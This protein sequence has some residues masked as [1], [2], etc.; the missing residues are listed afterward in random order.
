MVNNIDRQFEETFIPKNWIA[1]ITS[2]VEDTFYAGTWSGAWD[3]D[4]FSKQFK[5]ICSN[6]IKHPKFVNIR[7]F[8]VWS[9]RWPRWRQIK[10]IENRSKLRNTLS[11]DSQWTK[12]G[13]HDILSV[14]WR[15]AHDVV[16]MTADDI[17]RYGWVVQLFTNVLEIP[18]LKNQ[19]K[20]IIK[21]YEQFIIELEK[22]AG[23]QGFSVFNW[24]TAQTWACVWTPITCTIDNPFIA[25]PFNRAWVMQGLYHEERMILGDKIQAWD[26]LVALKQDWFRSNGI[27][28]VRKWF[29]LQYGKNRYKDAPREE[30]MQAATPSVIYANAIAHANGRY[31]DGQEQIQINGIAHL[32]GGS[33]KWK[34]LEDMLWKNNLSAHFDNLYAIPEINKKVALWTKNDPDRGMKD[35]SEIASTRC[36]GQG[37]ITSHPN[38]VEANKF[39]AI[40][41]QHGIDGQIAGKVVET[42]ENTKPSITLENIR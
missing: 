16:A 19:Q 32:S 11:P 23:E 1:K 36:I 22:I 10:D 34:L 8:S 24:E 6:T 5:E 21:E 18:S 4:S 41:K 2:D 14:H 31:N 15:A 29:E 7:D 27:S 17:A 40:V 3:K 28:A 30:I 13:L 35:I 20:E 12:S 39:I 25:K 33:F 26:V 42:P 37:A 38:E 9:H